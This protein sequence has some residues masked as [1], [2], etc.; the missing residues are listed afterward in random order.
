MTTKDITVTLSQRNNPILW[1]TWARRKNG[2]A[3]L[4]CISF[5]ADRAKRALE[6]LETNEKLKTQH[7]AKVYNAMSVEEQRVFKA[8]Y[9]NPV[10][11]CWTE[12]VEADHVFGAGM[13]KDLM[14]LAEF[15]KPRDP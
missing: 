11:Q 14:A 8:A 4:R 15:T 2:L 12:E 1:L 13:L 3:E 7:D 10:V 9:G 5:A 6:Y